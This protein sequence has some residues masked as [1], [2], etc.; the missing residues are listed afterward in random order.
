MS[1][2]DIRRRGDLRVVERGNGVRN[3]LITIFLCNLLIDTCDE[4]DD[5]YRT[6]TVLNSIP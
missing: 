6:T 5:L 2:K 1:E 4:P 3:G